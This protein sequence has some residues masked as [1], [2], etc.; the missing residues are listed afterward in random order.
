MFSKK[1]EKAF[2]DQINAELFSYYLYLSM[3][4]WFT[5]KNLNGFATW[6]E[7]QAQEEMSHAMKFFRHIQERDGVVKLQAIKQ[8]QLTW[9]SPLE[10]FK[11]T[12]QHEKHV[13]S[14]INNLV[15]LAIKEKDHAS[16]AFLQWFVNE[17]VEEEATANEKLE[18]IKMAG[19]NHHTLFMIDRELGQRTFTPPAE[20]EEG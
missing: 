13:T 3:S 7:A 15:D 6:M 17:Q 18:E 4:A 11:A 16:N 1:M 8:P 10:V 14:L 12:L 9:K 5:T 20:G 2:N 19:S